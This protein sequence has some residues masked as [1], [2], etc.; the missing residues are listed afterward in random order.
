M[1]DLTIISIRMKKETHQELR[2]ISYLT[3]QPIAELVRQ[4]ID[5]YIKR[6]KNMLTENNTAV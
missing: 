3:D 5:M 2:K 6:S 4:G 1:K